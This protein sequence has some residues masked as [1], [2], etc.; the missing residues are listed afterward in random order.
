MINI[1][2]SA[3][4]FWAKAIVINGHIQLG[5]NLTQNALDHT[6]DLIDE[7]QCIKADSVV[8]RDYAMTYAGMANDRLGRALT[9]WVGQGNG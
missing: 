4:A 3:R 1:D 6:V 2:Y 8:V 9:T 5:A 7:M